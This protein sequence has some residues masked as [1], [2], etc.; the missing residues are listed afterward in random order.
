MSSVIDVTRPKEIKKEE[1]T[2]GNRSA[3][4]CSRIP[5][6]IIHVIE[7]PTSV[8]LRTVFFGSHNFL[9][10]LSCCA[11]RPKGQMK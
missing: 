2:R 6:N 11:V 5:Y 8:Y 7:V 4:T 9:M 3:C 1:E 10:G